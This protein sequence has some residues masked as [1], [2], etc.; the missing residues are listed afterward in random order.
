V[1]VMPEWDGLEAREKS[2]VDTSSAWR[3]AALRAVGGWFMPCDILDDYA[4][5]LQMIHHGWRGERVP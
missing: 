1:F 5:T 4:T 3:V 2:I